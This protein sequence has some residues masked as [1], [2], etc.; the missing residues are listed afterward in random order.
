L[1]RRLS[2]LLLLALCTIACQAQPER[3]ATPSA[4]TLRIAPATR[5]RASKILVDAR[6]HEPALT[7]ALQELARSHG[8][9]L[10]GLNHRLKT[11]P[12]LERKIQT[13]LLHGKA[14]A[15]RGVIISD[16]LRYT[17]L[18]EDEPAGHYEEAA[19]A[20]LGEL[21]GMGHKIRLVKNYWPRG[22]T[23]AGLNC[24]L[25][26]PDGFRWELQFHTI[27]SL[28]AVQEGHDLY[29]VL[30]LPTTALPKKRS[31]FDRLTQRWNWVLIP[32]GILEPPLV[33]A[34]EVQ[35]LHKRP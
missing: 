31:L 14:K 15:A 6:Q 25:A 30:R 4:Q 1:T 9:R 11:A 20:I 35:R 24:N 34:T 21:E 19:Q 5:T 17:Y 12:S 18:I 33:H 2:A 8:A 16:A 26:F 29:D 13:A 7:S 23:Y 27:G 3:S 10:Y 32:K 28:A 22:D